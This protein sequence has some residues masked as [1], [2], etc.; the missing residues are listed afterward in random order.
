MRRLALIVVVLLLCGLLAYWVGI[1]LEFEF[2]YWPLLWSA[3]HGKTWQGE[4]IDTLI[5]SRFPAKL[6]RVHWHTSSYCWDRTCDW[7]K[8][9]YARV[10]IFERSGADPRD[11]PAG[12]LH[13]LYRRSD[14]VILPAD[15][16]TATLFPSLMPPGWGFGYPLAHV[17]GTTILSVKEFSRPTG[18]GREPPTPSPATSTPSPTP[19]TPSAASPGRPSSS[20]ATP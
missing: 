11:R 5:E 6:Y 16:G 20:P 4:S 8:M 17:D 3:R 19:A 18:P 13:F 9:P 12:Y 2:P 7:K 14:G 15:K 10:D 1:I